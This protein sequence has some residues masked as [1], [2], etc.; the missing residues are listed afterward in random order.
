VCPP[1]VFKYITSYFP[2][3]PIPPYQDECLTVFSCCHNYIVEEIIVYVKRVAVCDKQILKT[4]IFKHKFR[5][6]TKLNWK[7]DLQTAV[8]CFI[9]RNVYKVEDKFVNENGKL[10]LFFF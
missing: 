5:N 9:L 8:T 2:F 3:S 1:L 4:E 6:R 10:N 7:W